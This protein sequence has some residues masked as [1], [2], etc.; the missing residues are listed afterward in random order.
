MNSIFT[1]TISGRISYQDFSSSTPE[2]FTHKFR[3]SFGVVHED[4]KFI[5][6]DEI[7]WGEVEENPARSKGS[8]AKNI[9]E[10]A[11]S[12]SLGIDLSAP[13]PAVSTTVIKDLSGKIYYYKA[14]NGITRKKADFYN[15]YTQGAMFDV[16]R[17]VEDE[18]RSAEYNR[19]VWLHLE[20]DNLPQEVNSI[21][22]IVNTCSEL[23]QSGFLDREEMLIRD[24]VWESCPNMATQDK[25][26]I[27][28]IVVRDE[29]VPT[30]T[31]SWRD[32]ECEEWIADKCLDDIDVDYNMAFHYFK[33][34]IY[35]L[36]KQYSETKKVQTVLQHYQNKADSEDYIFAQRVSQQN[37]WQEC[38]KVLKDVAL[39]MIAND[40][41]LPV[42]LIGHF[43]QVVS[44]DDKEDPNR[45]VPID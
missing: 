4:R 19:R 23:I 3:E 6:Y 41:E 30:K 35:S 13:L 33:D 34:R 7:Y 1:N 29:K 25:N 28:R 26:E 42:N 16:V 37:K 18:G 38:R 43:P 40:W 11:A 44:G 20:N 21:S 9:K 14:E 27:V 24:F 17:F 10:L 36:L 22:D 5:N 39:Y 32:N 31:I 2:M 15:N 45:I 8:S 12:R